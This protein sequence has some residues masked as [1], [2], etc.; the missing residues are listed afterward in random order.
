MK[1]TA[2]LFALLV[3]AASFSAVAVGTKPVTDVGTKPI[4]TNVGTKPAPK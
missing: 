3:G 4:S 1:Y 2:I